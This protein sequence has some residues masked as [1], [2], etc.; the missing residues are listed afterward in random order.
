[1]C[2]DAPWGLVYSSFI[3]TNTTPQEL[4]MNIAKN[5]E[6]IFVAALALA[7]VTTI[8]TA[9]VPA[10]RAN[11]AVALHAASDTNMAVVTITAKRLTAAQKA[12][13]AD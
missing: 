3:E 1:M 8:A 5:M 10:H 9:A 2:R 11:A 12:Q 6:I 7:S 4:I 13:L